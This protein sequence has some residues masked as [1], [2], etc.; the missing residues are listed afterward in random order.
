MQHITQ[1]PF[2]GCLHSH[3]DS[4]D[5]APGISKVEQLATSSTPADPVPYP[6]C[7]VKGSDPE[8]LGPNSEGV[9]PNILGIQTVTQ[10]QKT[11]KQAK[12]KK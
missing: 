8:C 2:L 11:T 10:T 7:T 4:I 12:Q 6:A 5:S 1:I 9:N 3:I